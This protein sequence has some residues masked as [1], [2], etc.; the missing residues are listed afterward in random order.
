[1]AGGVVGAGH[2][3]VWPASRGWSSSGEGLGE[4]GFI[5]EGRF[6]PD[7]PAPG[8]LSAADGRELKF[9]LFFL[10]EP[11][12]FPVGLGTPCTARIDWAE[13]PLPA[14][15]PGAAATAPA[16]AEYGAPEVTSDAADAASLAAA[17]APAA[18]GSVAGRGSTFHIFSAGFRR[19]EAAGSPGTSSVR[20]R[21]ALPAPAER[22]A[23]SHAPSTPIITPASTPHTVPQP[24]AGGT[25]VATGFSAAA[26]GGLMAVVGAVGA[27]IVGAAPACPAPAREAALEASMI[28]SATV[29]PTES[30]AAPCL[31]LPATDEAAGAAVP[32]DASAAGGV[33]T[34]ATVPRAEP[35]AEPCAFATGPMPASKA[36]SASTSSSRRPQR[37]PPAGGSWRGSAALLV[38]RLRVMKHLG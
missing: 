31:T 33:A 24:A 38:E 1:M 30:A 13:M 6:G 9:D 25:G 37:E 29:E 36:G 16:P 22:R 28:E 19:D 7:G 32:A 34:G 23:H 15:S 12:A 8:R 26:A 10:C 20:K 35:L 21:P 4:F 17:A 3:T 2:S 5:A 18:L 14:P 11:V 27:A